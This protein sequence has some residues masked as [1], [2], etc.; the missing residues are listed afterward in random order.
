M[1]IYYIY[2]Y[3]I[4]CNGNKYIY[5]IYLYIS[6]AMEIKKVSREDLTIGRRKRGLHGKDNIWTE[7]ERISRMKG[8]MCK[9]HS[10]STEGQS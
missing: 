9:T 8:M 7:P 6:S 3:N 10:M 1:N 2:L 4:K 5:Y